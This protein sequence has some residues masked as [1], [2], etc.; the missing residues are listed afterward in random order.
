LCGLQ[1]GAVGP[2][3]RPPRRLQF[4]VEGKS[5]VLPNSL[6]DLVQSCFFFFA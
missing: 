2:A 6:G 4:V 5:E 1:L 3:A